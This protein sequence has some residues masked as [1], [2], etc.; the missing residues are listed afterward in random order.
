MELELYIRQT[1]LKDKQGQEQYISFATDNTLVYKAGMLP[2]QRRFPSYGNYINM[3]GHVSDLHRL[4][5]TWTTERNADGLPAPGATQQKRSSSGT[6]TLEGEAYSLLRQW[7]IDDESARFNS[8]D[9]MIKH[10][11]AGNYDNW[12]VKATDINWCEGDICTMNVH[13]K[14]KDDALTCIR[15][16][17]IADNWQGWFG[18]STSPA[19]GRKHPR[20][21]YCTEVRPNGMLV[22][23]WWT[24]TQLMSVLGPLMLVIAPV[25]NS[26]IWTLKNIIY[27]IINF[28]LGILNRK[29]LDADKLNYIDYKDVKEIFG[30]FFVES[31]GCGREHPAPLIRD[32]ISN[33][34][35]KCGVHVD[36]TTVP[37]FFAQSMLIETSADRY[38]GR[39]A[40]WRSNPHYNACY[41]Y[42]V[43]D[44]GIR[45][46]DELNIFNGAVKNQTDWWLPGNAPLLTL[47]EL[48]DQLKT[49]YNA[50]WRVENNKLCFLRKDYWLN[51]THA[52]DFSKGTKDSQLLVEGICYEWDETPAP[53]YGKGIYS[54]DP[55]DVCGNNACNQANG[56]V[57]FGDIDK[58]PGLDG[59]MDKTVPFGAAKFRLDGAG[60]DYLFDAM[61]Q[62]INTT[63]ITG[64]VWTT[65]LF[66]TV[67]GFFRDYAN[68][69]LLLK[70]ETAVMPKILIWDG[71]RYDN[72]RCVQ[73]Y[74]ASGSLSQPVPVPNTHYNP[75]SRMWEHVHE[76]QT[77]VSGRKLV[78]PPQPVGIYEVRGLFGALVTLQAA[79]L[80]N[81]PMYFEPGYEG[82]LWDW[83]HW[84]D[85]PTLNKQWHR[86]FSLKMDLCRDALNRVQ[87]FGDASA[88]ILGQ[89][90]KLP[91]QRINEGRIT[92]IEVSYDT[93]GDT[94][95]Y[96]ELKGIV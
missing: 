11:G 83:F 3:T 62:V 77:K 57:S 63:L 69:A 49:V 59:V 79:K 5:L 4:K 84:I 28:I 72:A 53:V 22:T 24:M 37:L 96:I 6:L 16:T 40:Q 86:K 67:N 43:A 1:V 89:K 41:F 36:D 8:A 44:K 13:L 2:V 82:T 68:Y 88:I 12:V 71:A 34:C 26:I 48:L 29:K 94:G 92:E 64:S 33:V 31:A 54:P 74:H 47:D 95:P 42:A 20:F 25:I 55:S 87:P 51:T 91:L 15:N 27:P 60:T 93:T 78:P 39:P 70:Q 9:V 10:T 35:G 56:Y 80:V 30:N 50:E 73:P 46:F 18:D 75:N 7:L 52:F 38:A 19:S 65:P 23:L 58:A 76:P 17:W 32:Y 61:Q 21:S 66:S 45:R 81:Y 85:D 90:I 14:Q